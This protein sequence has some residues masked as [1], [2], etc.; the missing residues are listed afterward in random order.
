V[1]YIGSKVS[2][3][4]FLEHVWRAVNDGD[5]TRFLDPFAGTGAVGRRFRELGLIVTAGDLQQYAVAL[6]RA[7]VALPQEPTFEKL[8]KQLPFNEALPENAAPVERVLDALNTMPL[9][10]GGFIHSTYSPAAKR[11]YFTEENAARA[12]VI[13]QTIADWRFSG[14]INEGE[15]DYLLASLIE[16]LDAVANTASVYGAFLKDF[17][18]SAAKPLV[19]KPL[20][21]AKQGPAGYAVQADANQLVRD[22][23]TDVLY[24]DP[25]Y[26]QRQYGA[27]YHVLETVAAYDSPEVTGTTG[28]RSGYERS[29][30]CSRTQVRRAFTDLIANAQTRHI[31]V[32]YNDEGL[33]PLADL[34]ALLAQRGE[35]RTFQTDYSR[36]KADNSRAYSRAATVEYVN[37]VRVTR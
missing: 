29:A 19:V 31:L 5:E 17:K 22:T 2:L 35:V 15:Y 9:K 8:L 1:N 23:E 34:R 14:E 37:Y 4:P 13:R 26:N 21:L 11:L 36:Y 30:Y 12:D 25:P 20:N 24:L 33:L 27:N 16:N 18:A 10:F 6:N 28:L 7:Y 32:S 3:L